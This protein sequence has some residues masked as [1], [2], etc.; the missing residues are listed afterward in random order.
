MWCC[1][2]MGMEYFTRNLVYFPS[3]T[4]K[5]PSCVSLTS[6]LLLPTGTYFVVVY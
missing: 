1:K 3:F 5:Y 6:L 4:S 2:A